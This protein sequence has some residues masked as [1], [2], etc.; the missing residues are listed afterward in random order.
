[1]SAGNVKNEKR[2][3]LETLLL[4]ENRSGSRYTSQ[5]ITSTTICGDKLMMQVEATK[6]NVNTNGRIGSAL[7][8]CNERH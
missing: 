6:Y 4:P 2:C 8:E 5:F 7:Y 1:M 3:N